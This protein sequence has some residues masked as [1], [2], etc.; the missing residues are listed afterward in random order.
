MTRYSA[1]ASINVGRSVSVMTTV[2]HT[3]DDQVRDLRILSGITYR[4]R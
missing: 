3:R 1:T 2:E 4:I